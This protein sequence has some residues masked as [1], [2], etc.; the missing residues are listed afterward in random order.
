MAYL[1]SDFDSNK[2]A[3]WSWKGKRIKLSPIH[4]RRMLARSMEVMVDTIMSN[5]LYQFDSRVSRQVEGGP[6]GLEITGVLARLV[7]LWWD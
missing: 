3:K 5:H 6:I 2:N 4:K 1:D 7:M